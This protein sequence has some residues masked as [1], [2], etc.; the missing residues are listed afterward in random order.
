MNL[1]RADFFAAVLAPFTARRSSAL[2]ILALTSSLEFGG[3]LQEIGLGHGVEPLFFAVR[4][5]L[6]TRCPWSPWPCAAERAGRFEVVRSIDAWNA[7][8]R[9]MTLDFGRS[10]APSHDRVTG[11]LLFDEFFDPLAVGVLI[12]IRA[13]TRRSVTR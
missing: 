2:V 8:I 11:A 7:D 9:S 1:G 4:R 3:A 10:S 12:A 6:Q 13:P 5:D